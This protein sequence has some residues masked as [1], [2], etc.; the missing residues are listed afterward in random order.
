MLVLLLAAC[1]HAKGP[2]APTVAPLR[3]TPWPTLAD[4]ACVPTAAAPPA[5]TCVVLDRD[6]LWRVSPTDLRVRTAIVGPNAGISGLRVEAGVIQLVGDCPDVG[7]CARPLD[8]TDPPTPPVGLPLAESTPA[9][10]DTDADAQGVLFAHQFTAATHHLDR[11]GFYRLVLTPD[12]GRVTLLPGGGSTLLRTGHGIKAVRLGL[13]DAVQ[14]WPATLS[15][16]PTGQELYVL[17]WPDGTLRALD[18]LTLAPHWSLPLDAPA[19]GLYVDGGGRYLVGELGAL[20]APPSVAAFSADDPA[21][22]T[23][24]LDR[25]APWPEPNGATDD[26][27]LRALDAPPAVATFVVDLANRSVAL[28]I[29]GRL[30]RAVAIPAS[31]GEDAGLLVATTDAIQYIAPS[32]RPPSQGAAPVAP[33]PVAPSPLA[34]ASP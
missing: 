31:P 2:V 3:Y 1:H 16:H 15:L 28:A 13:P 9:P 11:I 34:P 33:P 32:P 14:P 5:T 29:P 19:F 27:V 21:G 18:P 7:R 12:Q 26:E 17:A 10:E 20:E 4:V 24:A 6:G 23:S 30:R 25:I 22:P 8:A